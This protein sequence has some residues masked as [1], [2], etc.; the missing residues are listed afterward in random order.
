[1]VSLALL[2]FLYIRWSDV[3]TEQGQMP[4]RGGIEMPL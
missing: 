1:M 3:N 2:R 4:I